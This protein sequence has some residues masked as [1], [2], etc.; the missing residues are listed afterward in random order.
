MTLGSRS[1]ERGR[2]L[3]HLETEI[4]VVGAQS[5]RTRHVAAA[6]VPAGDTAGGARGTGHVRE[7][8][9]RYLYGDGLFRMARWAPVFDQ[10]TAVSAPRARRV[11]GGAVGGPPSPDCGD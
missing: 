10:V 8:H 1:M 5:N 4:C 7:F 3:E 9:R 6:A 11:S 2:Q